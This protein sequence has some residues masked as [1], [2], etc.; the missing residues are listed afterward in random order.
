MALKTMSSNE[1]KQ[2][3]ESLIDATSGPDDAVIVESHG[4][5]KVAMISY[6]RFRQVQDIGRAGPACPCLGGTSAARRAHRQPQQR[7]HRGAD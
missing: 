5:P 1:A 4:E 3:W 6:D 2:Q 7:S